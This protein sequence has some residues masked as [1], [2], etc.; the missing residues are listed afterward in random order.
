ME[1]AVIALHQIADKVKRVDF[2]R[3][4]WQAIGTSKVSTL[5]VLSMKASADRLI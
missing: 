4:T 5:C 2:V 1:F 3:S